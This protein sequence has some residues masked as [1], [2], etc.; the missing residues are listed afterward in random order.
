[1]AS[2]LN[3]VS[4]LGATRQLDVTNAGLQQT[5]ERLTTGRRIN[6]AS[7]D[8]AGLGIS[9]QLGADIRIASQGKRN[10]NDG[11]SYLQ[12]AD[13]VLDE[14][15][16]LPDPRRGTGRA[17]QDRHH[18]QH[19]PDGH[20]RR[21]P[22]H[23]QDDRGYRSEHQ[24]QRCHSVHFWRPERIGGWFLPGVGDRGDHQQQQQHC[25]RLDRQHQ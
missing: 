20:Q 4:A 23:H 10:A 11:I 22:E 17:G 3:N 16:N 5:I 21:V 14:V 18:Q 13:S 1:M 7:D 12:V 2:I 15:T 6:R 9:N 25:T 8:A 24:V 19:Q